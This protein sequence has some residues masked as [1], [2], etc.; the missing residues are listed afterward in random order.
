M[1]KKLEEIFN[2]VPACGAKKRHL[3]A[4]D[5]ACGFSGVLERV[6]VDSKLSS[7]FEQLPKI[8]ADAVGEDF[9]GLV[10]AGQNL[11]LM[12]V[13]QLV[14]HGVKVEALAGLS[15][16]GL[17]TGATFMLYLW[18]SVAAGLGVPPVVGTPTA[19]IVKVDY[20]TRLDNDDNSDDDDDDDNPG[21][22]K[23][24]LQLS[25]YVRI[26]LSYPSCRS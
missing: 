16:V 1:L 8:V 4:R 22:K 13:S 19:N 23:P 25:D 6:S 18:T 5:L 11:A 21:C 7:V 20:K 12:T 24:L 3:Q 26:Q 14:A 15:G 10:S 17:V 2:S 9:I